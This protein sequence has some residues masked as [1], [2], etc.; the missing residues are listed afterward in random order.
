MEF[1]DDIIGAQPNLAGVRTL[2]KCTL[3]F[4]LTWQL[5]LAGGKKG[6]RLLITGGAAPAPEDT[7]TVGDEPVNIVDGAKGTMV[8]GSLL[9][10]PLSFLPALRA[11]VAAVREEARKTFS[12]LRT[13]ASGC[14]CK[15]GHGEGAS[16]GL[17][18][19]GRNL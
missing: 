15:P 6:P 17:C 12:K 13:T 16:R 4:A 8:L 2:R 10:P 18:C 7:P 1:V 11:M 3:A 14:P 19:Q 9:D 5:A